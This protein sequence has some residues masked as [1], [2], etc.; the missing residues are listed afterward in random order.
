MILAW[1]AIGDEVTAG[2]AQAG[3]TALLIDPAT[4]PSVLAQAAPA[5]EVV[6]REPT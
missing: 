4:F 2:A 5:Y 1:H 3:A 6:D